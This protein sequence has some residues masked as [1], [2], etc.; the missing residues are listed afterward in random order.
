MISTHSISTNSLRYFPH[1]SGLN[2]EDLRRIAG[3]TERVEFEAGE[4]L[5]VEGSVATHFC[6]LMSGEV[7][8]VYRL[9][10]NRTV[11]ADVLV[12]GEAF[13]WSALLEPHRLTA[14]CVGNRKG[15]YLRIEAESLR[16]LC[17]QN[18]NSGYRLALEISKLL[19]DRL[20]ALRVQ[21]AAAL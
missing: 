16:R 4:E 10:D 13:G 3:I 18:P 1:F 12:A 19:R 21:I 5:L 2:E 6:L 14:T 11:A 15:E 7:Q 9:G 20:S 17:E 8:I